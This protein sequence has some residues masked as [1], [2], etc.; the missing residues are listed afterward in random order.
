MENLVND[1]NRIARIFSLFEGK[2][3][4]IGAPMPSVS[5]IAAE[6]SDPY[7][8]LASTIISLR[9]K[10]TVTLQASRRLFRS[11]PDLESLADGDEEMIAETIKPAGFYRRKA[12]QLKNIA[13]ILLEKYGGTVPDSL[14]ELLSLPGVGIKTASL[15]LNLSYGIEAICVD[16]HVHQIANRTGL[17]EIRTPEETEKA[18]RRTLPRE[19]WIPINDLFVRY[20]QHICLP[21][22]PLCTECPLAPE[23]PKRDVSVHR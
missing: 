18:L 21:T 17:A 8:I 6:D 19:Y 13:R 14:D 16:C 10:D 9:T 23:C 2:L 3:S 22:S 12:L 7:R 20:G 1:K 15:V 5:I 4:E 11:F